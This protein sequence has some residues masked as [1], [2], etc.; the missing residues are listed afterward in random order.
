M[1][2]SIDSNKISFLKTNSKV[3]STVDLTTCVVE[4]LYVKPWYIIVYI[5]NKTAYMTDVWE[6][7]MDFPSTFCAV[8]C[9]YSSRR[10]VY[11]LIPPLGKKN[12]YNLHYIFAKKSRVRRQWPRLCTKYRVPTRDK[13]QYSFQV[14]THQSRR[15]RLS[16]VCATV[17]VCIV[18]SFHPEIKLSLTLA[19]YTS[20]Y[21]R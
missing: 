17:A 12:L 21:S 3:K 9:Q 1:R 15:K 13:D 19:K 16:A 4:R 6:K 20:P 14:Y 7:S 5:V 8:L 10:S 11:T 18:L 2:R